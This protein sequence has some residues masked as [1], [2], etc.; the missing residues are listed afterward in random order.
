MSGTS[1][2]SGQLAPGT[3]NLSGGRFTINAVLLDPSA[4]V[5]IYDNPTAASGTILIHAINAGT[6][7]LDIF[8]SNA[9]R[10]ETGVTVVVAGAPAYVFTGSS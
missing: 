1:V 2:S 10:A 9:V 7:S 3:Y 5:T 4:E 6:S 8:Y